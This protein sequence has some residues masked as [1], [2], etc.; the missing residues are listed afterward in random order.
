[1][2][3]PG[4]FKSAAAKLEAMA[5]PHHLDALDAAKNVGYRS[6]MPSKHTTTV[7]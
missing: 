7:H 3:R 5:K 2:R 6:H 1:M 4:C